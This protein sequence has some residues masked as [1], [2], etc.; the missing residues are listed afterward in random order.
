MKNPDLDKIFSTIPGAQKAADGFIISGEN[1][2]FH[3]FGVLTEEQT[4]GLATEETFYLPFCTKEE[5]LRIRNQSS[6]SDYLLW[7]RA[8]AIA[9]SPRAVRVFRKR[10]AGKKGWS[11]TKYYRDNFSYDKKYLEMAGGKFKSKTSNIPAGMAFV[12]DVNAMCIHTKFG[13]V[14]VANEA[15]TFFLY[16]MN[17]VFLGREHGIDY[18]DI[19]ASLAI[20]IRIMLGSE[21]LDFDIDP[22]GDLPPKIHKEISNYTELQLI[23]IFGHEYAHHT[24]GHLSSSSIKKYPL[25]T[26]MHTERSD[27][28]IK[29]YSYEHK[30]EYNAD[31]YAIKKIR[32]NNHFRSI[33]ADSAFL[34]FIYFDILDHVLQYLALRDNIS[35]T[36]PNPLDR[37]WH[38]RGKLKSKIGASVD[39]IRSY[40]KVS[41]QIKNLLIKEWLPFRI[42][43]LERYGSIYLP[44][45]KR[46]ILIDRIDF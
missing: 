7:L 33:M 27:I 9:D 43:E 18:S 22:R 31:L 23:F 19:S 44:S 25:Q 4:K 8:E 24:L 41:G 11:L 45:Y 16:Y 2:R 6:S 29:A 46:K 39:T 13:N 42:D 20:A 38:L 34:I 40:L 1:A 26:I 12:R 17:I 36:H 35:K 5:I 32:N 10:A 15:L 3:V 14:I 21:S 28:D 37:L 30:K